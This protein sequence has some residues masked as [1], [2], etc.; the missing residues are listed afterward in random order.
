MLKHHD[1]CTVK[2][3][4]PTIGAIVCDTVMTS[5]QQDI[6]LTKQ[7]NKIAVIW[8]HLLLHS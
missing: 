8:T 4:P 2:S 3:A 1:T 7:G 6:H 5:N